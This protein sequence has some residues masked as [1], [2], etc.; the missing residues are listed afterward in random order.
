MGTD[1]LFH[2]QKQ[3]TSKSLHRRK[4]KRASYDR[5]LI[6]CEGEKTEPNYFKEIR[7]HFRLKS[8]NIEIEDNTSGSAPISVVNNA[9]KKYKKTKD[10]DRVYCVFD[11]DTHP[12]YDQAL[13][14]I[15]RARLAKGHKIIAAQ[16]VPC[17]EFWILLHFEYTTGSFSATGK[18]SF[19][20]SVINKIKAKNYIPD[21]EKGA[22]DLSPILIPRLDCAISNA[23][24]VEQFHIDSYTETDNPSTKVHE[25]VEYLKTLKTIK[26]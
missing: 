10:Y 20:T 2:K 16:S 23:K 22:K 4:A 25:L 3:R 9:L 12:T 13:D 21:Y 8:V 1:N 19:C 24:K 17:F 5:V 7:T 14:K 6:V 18:A 15:S 26:I 11:K